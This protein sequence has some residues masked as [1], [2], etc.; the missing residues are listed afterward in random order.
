MKQGIHHES[1]DAPAAAMRSADIRHELYPMPHTEAMDV[2][3]KDLIIRKAERRIHVRVQNCRVQTAMG[4]K[5][6][7]RDVQDGQPV[8]QLHTLCFACALFFHALING[9]RVALPH[10]FPAQTDLLSIVK[11][12]S[13]KPIDHGAD[14]SKLHANS[15]HFLFLSFH[16]ASS[17]FGEMQD[18]STESF[19]LRPEFSSLKNRPAPRR[20]MSL[21]RA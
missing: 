3:K 11:S 15:Y 10:Q 4:T 17:S 8:A 21:S 12:S 18:S 14:D 7:D 19:W 1:V 2:R 6:R 20:R 13:S 9:D 16:T 5:R